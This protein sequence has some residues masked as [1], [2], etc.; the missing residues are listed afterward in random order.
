MPGVTRTKSRERPT[1]K[2]RRDGTTRARFDSID[3]E[4]RARRRT[5]RDDDACV[6][7]ARARRVGATGERVVRSALGL[8]SRRWEVCRAR[9]SRA[10]RSLRR[11]RPRLPARRRTSASAVTNLARVAGRG[12]GS[13]DGRG[14]RASRLAGHAP[15]MSRGMAAEWVCGRPRGADAREGVC[16]PRRC[17]GAFFRLVVETTKTC[18][19]VGFSKSVTVQVGLLSGF[20]TRHK[21]AVWR[22]HFSQKSRL[23]ASELFPTTR[24]RHDDI[25]IKKASRQPALLHLRKPP[26]RIGGD[27]SLAAAVPPADRDRTPTQAPHAPRHDV[28]LRQRR[29]GRLRAH[30]G[31]RRVSPPRFCFQ[32]CFVSHVGC[33]FQARS[34]EA[35]ASSA[36]PVPAP[37][38]SID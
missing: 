2:R 38:L 28:G 30:P 27:R 32:A 34:R 23:F 6:P 33:G 29:R 1:G 16:S 21:R 19:L 12:R 18:A 24:A 35:R 37:N 8:I 36:R 7:G 11:A 15:V 13:R 25:P 4:E 3:G 14:A 5:V 9:V 31:Q 26:G 10:P 22:L 17:R 20:A